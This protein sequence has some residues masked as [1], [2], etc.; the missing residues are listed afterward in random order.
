VTIEFNLNEINESKISLNGYFIC[1]CIYHNR[2]DLILDYIKNHTG[3]NIQDVKELEDNGWIKIINKSE[4]IIF[5]NLQIEEKFRIF[6]EKKDKPEKDWINEWLEMFPKG[7]KSG[8]YYIK[9][10]LNGCRKKMR[11]FTSTHPEYTKE[12]II[13]ATQNYINRCEHNGY[14]YMKIAPYFIEKD[15]VSMLS[16]ECEAIITNIDEYTNDNIKQI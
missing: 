16:G 6:V 5:E 7:V 2:K 15:G 13:K 14:Q 11:K 10:D 3:F 4:K 1:Y 12:T 9:T 8:G